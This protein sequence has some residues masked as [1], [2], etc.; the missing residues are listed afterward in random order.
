MSSTYHLYG[1]N[2]SENQKANLAKA[3][4]NK[5]GYVLRL[6]HKQLQGEDEIPLTA[7]QIKKINN[8]L[9]QKRG[10]EIKVS[11]T[12]A[13][14]GG[15]MFS[16]LATLASKALPAIT[17][18]GSKVLPTVG[19]VATHILPGI[20]Q[21]ISSTLASLG[22]EKLFGG[23]IYLEPDQIPFFLPY[24]DVFTDEMEDAEQ[25]GNG[26]QI[27][28]SAEQQEGFL[29]ALAVS[30]GIP[31]LIKALTGSGLQLGRTSGKGMRV[32]RCGRIRG[33]CGRGLQ[34]APQNGNGLHILTPEASQQH[35]EEIFRMNKK[36][37]SGLLLGKNSPF[38]GIP[39][40]VSLL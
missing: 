24:T 4:Q 18:V 9:L 19:K 14:K 8:A 39:L 38:K 29:G 34:L 37:G 7:T 36:K 2:L 35:F 21:G 20:A 16:S 25:S 22:I 12:Q 30:V 1:L 15:S 32:G 5:T 11:R 23:T 40:L 6:T 31:L 17:K 10:V 27:D 26:L 13:M 28:L 33:D 3:Y